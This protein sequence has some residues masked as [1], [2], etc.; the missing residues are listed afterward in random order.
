MYRVGRRAG[1]ECRGRLAWWSGI[2]KDRDSPSWKLSFSRLFVNEINIRLVEF[3]HLQRGLWLAF[4]MSNIRWLNASFVVIRYGYGSGL[5]RTILAACT[6]Y[7]PRA[8]S[9]ICNSIMSFLVPQYAYIS[10]LLHWVF[11][12]SLNRLDL[13]VKRKWDF[14]CLL[15]VKF[16]YWWNVMQSVFSVLSL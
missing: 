3:L 7:R 1:R 14:A 10:V 12:M 8:M 5:W 15:L 16:S 13:R 4:K 9:S 2:C 6:T 11:R